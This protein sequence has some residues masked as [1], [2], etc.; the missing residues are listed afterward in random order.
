MCVAREH[1]VGAGLNGSVPAVGLVAQSHSESVVLL[2]D[3][4]K[5]RSVT[6]GLEVVETD[7]RKG[8][9]GSS[10]CD[11]LVDQ[12]LDAGPFERPNGQVGIGRVVMISQDAPDP[13]GRFQSLESLNE[14][15]GIGGTPIQLVTGEDNEVSAQSRGQLGDLSTPPHRR[16]WAGVD[17]GNLQNLEPIPCWGKLREI[18]ADTPDRRQVMGADVPHPVAAQRPGEAERHLPL[19]MHLRQIQ[20]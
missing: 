19:G 11:R 10:E 20:H 5:I 14:P 1:Q 13:Q 17:I 18:Q 2:P 3:D 15:L 16:K 4:I 12:R 7:Q 6:R 8:L 9:V